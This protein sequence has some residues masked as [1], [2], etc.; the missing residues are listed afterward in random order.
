MKI[1]VGLSV[2]TCNDFK[3]HWPV[4]TAAVIVAESETAAREALE[5]ELE[6]VGLEQTQ[7]FTLVEL[8]IGLPSV[9]ILRDGEY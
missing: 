1:G 8:H 7:P 9:R 6:S 2:Y 4:G 5:S 3:G